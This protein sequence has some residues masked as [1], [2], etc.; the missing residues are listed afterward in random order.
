MNKKDLSVL[1]PKNLFSNNKISPIYSNFR[2]QLNTTV[3]KNKFLVAVSG[4]SDS[5]A[6]SA[7]C[8]IYS[9]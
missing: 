2:Y 6:L 9:E 8:K 7:L 4:G 3:K 5:L 1:K